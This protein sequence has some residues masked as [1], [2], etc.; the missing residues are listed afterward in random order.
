MSLALR[1]AAGGRSYVLALDDFD[2][3]PPPPPAPVPAPDPL[4]GLLEAARAEGFRA[5]EAAGAEAARASLQA[6][7]L[8]AL[9]AAEAAFAASGAD[10]RARA[11]ADAAAIART[12][13]AALLA[14]LPSLAERH[15]EA[16]VVRFAEVL[17]PALAE[18]PCV[19]MRVAAPV[20]EAVAAHF[21]AQPRIEV[22]A[23]PALAPGDIRLAWRGGQAERL[24]AAARAA[25]DDLLANHGLG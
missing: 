9:R 1:S 16:E 7:T 24:A 17:L 21:A 19:T 2:A 4:P 15:A 8:A 18:E 12:T 20:A 14:A 6:A 10:L 22:Q 13:F 25:I 23:D 5:G 11:E 3:P